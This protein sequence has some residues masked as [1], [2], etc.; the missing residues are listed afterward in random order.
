MNKNSFNRN[1]RR[2]GTIFFQ[3][4]N[5]ASRRHSANMAFI[6]SPYLHGPTMI[7]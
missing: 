1:A 3:T 7:P 5:I 6:F 2:F 4:T